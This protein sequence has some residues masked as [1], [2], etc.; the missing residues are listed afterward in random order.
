MLWRKPPSNRGT[1]ILLFKNKTSRKK[2]GRTKLTLKDPPDD[3]Q[4]G[5]AG[6]QSK[7]TSGVQRPVESGSEGEKEQEKHKLRV[8]SGVNNIRHQKS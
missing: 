8:K 3:G 2:L 5:E 1:K 7:V 4:S 6:G